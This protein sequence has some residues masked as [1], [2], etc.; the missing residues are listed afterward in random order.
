[1]ASFSYVIYDS[2][3]NEFSMSDIYPNSRTLVKNLMPLLERYASEEIK[4]EDDFLHKYEWFENDE[5]F[6]EDYAMSITY[7]G[8]RDCYGLSVHAKYFLN[9]DVFCLR[10]VIKLMKLIHISTKRATDA[11]DAPK[12]SLR[13]ISHGERFLVPH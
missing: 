2:A 13:V 3:K 7:M 5:L 6:A 12:R 9:L 11:T 10:Y 8:D 4:T 1:M